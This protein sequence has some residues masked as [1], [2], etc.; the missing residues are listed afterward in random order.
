VRICIIGKYPPIQ[1]G[2][3]ARTYRTAHALA[4][5]GH[6][7]HVVT[8]AKEVTPPFRIHMRQQDWLRCEARD[9]GGSVQLHWTDPVD[10]SQ[11]YIPM[12]SPFVSKLAT[13]AAGIHAGSPFDVI[14]SHYLEPYGVAGH[15]AAQMTGVPHVVRMAGSDAGRLWHHPQLELLYDHVLRAAD[16]VVAVGRVAD[17]AAQRGVR[18]ER[19]AAGGAYSIAE[20]FSPEG[21][22]LDLDALRVE[23]AE[24]SELQ[25]MVWGNFSGQS[26]H[27]GVYGKL[28]DNKGSFALVEAMQRLKQAGL[29][30]GLVALAHG[31][32]QIEGRFR[33]RITELGLADRVLQIPF[34]PH[35]RVPEFLRGCLA[36]CCL[37]QDFPITV[38]S[39]I[40]PLEVLHSGSCLVASTEMIR[41]LPQWQRLPHGYGCVAV[42]DVDDVMELSGKLAAIVRQ[43]ELAA[44]VGA[45]GR[46]FAAARQE[47]VEFPDKL[48]RILEAA[49]QR[50]TLPPAPEPGI[51][52]DTANLFPLTQV[53]ATHLGLEG[54][55]THA[56]GLEYPRQVLTGLEQAVIA[57]KSDLQ[58]FA[59]AVETEIAIATA[60]SEIGSPAA[61]TD[62]LFRVDVDAWALD[63]R[64][65]GS[66][67]PIRDARLRILRFEHDL[68]VLQGVVT[69][70]DFPTR[71]GP[72]PSYIVVAGSEP[73]LVDSFTARF[74][75]VSDGTQTVEQIIDL[76][77]QE[78][79]HPAQ[80]DRLAWIEQL[81]V[82]G[83]IG[84]RASKQGS[85]IP[86]VQATSR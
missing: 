86:A 21:P 84:V 4:A 54:P 5:R 49:A 75:E 13:I 52:D 56:G 14:F 79:H 35:W 85:D 55:R 41:K 12:A 59:V 3:S 53:A 26:P 9:S 25:D 29:N 27:F 74:L 83:M 17:R 60:M 33:A 47:D 80:A 67:T 45:R 40:V 71:L 11:T 48:E 81:L 23:V 44:S 30:I 61:S 65:L 39:P 46:S 64:S 36:V 18:P 28:G 77:A 42:K 22:V 19:I 7:V 31:R 34:L 20:D 62:P 68:S 58:P 72:G 66:L 73:L 51:G 6:E 70:D 69:A 10:R 37:E 15:L 8:N 57:G 78:F 2:V 63:S 76:I 16:F 1:G 50:R 38:H 82:S 32:P 43:P 24:N